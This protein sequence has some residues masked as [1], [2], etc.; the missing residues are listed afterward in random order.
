MGRLAVIVELQRHPDHV[1]SLALQQR[2]D[3]G[4]IH[5]AGHRDD[6][7]RVLGATGEVE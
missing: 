6:D 5:P 3:D 4:G 1:V 7:T 2:G